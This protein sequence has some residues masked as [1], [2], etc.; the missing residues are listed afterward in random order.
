MQNAKPYWTAALPL[1][2]LSAMISGDP[3]YRLWMALVATCAFTAMQ[4]LLP[5]CRFRG[6]FYFSPV[7]IALFLF[8]LKLVV[9][10]ALIMTVGPQS[11]VL[12]HLP[13]MASMEAAL[14]IDTIA[15]IALCLG[16]SL[17]PAAKGN[18]L[19]VANPGIPLVLAF[20]AL[21][22]IA[23]VAE[24][25]SPARLIQYFTEPSI[26]TEMKLELEGTL[27]GLIGTFFK[28]FFAF[29]LVAAWCRL[30]ERSLPLW[31]VSL[32]GLLAAIGI[33]LANMTY[34]FNRAAFVFPLLCLAAVYHN[35]V[36]RIPL[37]AA[38]GT[39]LIALPILIMISSYRSDLMAGKQSA[40]NSPLQA[41]LQATAD[42]VQGYAVGPQYTGLFYEQLGWGET[43]Y[44]GATLI[45]SAMSPAPILGKAFRDTSG[46]AIFNKALY[47]ISGIEDQI[48]P[49]DTELFANFHLPG[50]IAGLFTLG[51][52][53]IN[54][55]SW[56]HKA[57][58]SFAAFSLQYAGLWTAML[59]AW[60][61]SIYS[62]ILIYFFAPVYAYMLL[63]MAR[64]FIRRPAAMAAAH[65][66][67]AR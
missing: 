20:A 28:P 37:I 57:S 56:I 23:L 40:N 34:S 10:P 65:L 4:W 8:L 3:R 48:I 31:Q 45:A 60:S 2:T 63:T 53:L 42:N 22:L 19:D 17:A 1:I 64:G 15:Y 12:S 52:L 5:R 61:L 54:M 30:S 7:N 66:G 58:S 35:R 39:A 49:F 27:T 6:E 11:E 16:V 26:V 50:V 67:G 38:A 25:R 43:L 47:G 24:F 13:A 55:E 62:Q 29:S 33:T 18:P 9:A 21:G 36:R 14:A 32:S 46:P 59:T 51:M 41:A 44:S